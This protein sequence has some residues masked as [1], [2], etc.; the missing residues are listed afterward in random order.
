MLD[1]AIDPSFGHNTSTA[2]IFLA[3][4]LILFVRCFLPILSFNNPFEQ[5][6]TAAVKPKPTPMYFKTT[7][8]SGQLQ[9]TP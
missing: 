9:V 2:N 1:L 6:P 7:A 8:Q 4:S 3:G 5:S